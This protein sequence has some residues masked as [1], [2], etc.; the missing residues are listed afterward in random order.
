MYIVDICCLKLNNIVVQVEIC[1]QKCIY[2]VIPCTLQVCV[3]HFQ[4]TGLT[5]P[6]QHRTITLGDDSHW[7]VA[8]EPIT[9]ELP[10]SRVTETTNG[11]SRGTYLCVWMVMFLINYL[12][13]YILPILIDLPLLSPHTADRYIPYYQSK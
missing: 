11:S 10:R 12:Q 9:E 4:R 13:S 6:Q 7:N 1:K 5:F 2:I 3:L 8:R